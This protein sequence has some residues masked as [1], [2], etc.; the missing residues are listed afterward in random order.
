MYKRPL[1]FVKGIWILYDEKGRLYFFEYTI[2]VA[3]CKGGADLQ[4]QVKMIA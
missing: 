1:Y 3:G 2:A 4:T